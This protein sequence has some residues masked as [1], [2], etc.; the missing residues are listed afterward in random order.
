MGK[1]LPNPQIVPSI[2]CSYLLYVTPTGVITCDNVINI[3]LSYAVE[4][5]TPVN[6]RKFI[7]LPA[8]EVS[9]CLRDFTFSI[10]TNEGITVEPLRETDFTSVLPAY[11]DERIFFVLPRGTTGIKQIVTKEMTES[12]KVSLTF[13]VMP[14]PYNYN[15]ALA[16][17]ISDVNIYQGDQIASNSQKISALNGRVDAL[18]NKRL[19]VKQVPLKSYPGFFKIFGTNDQNDIL[20]W[21]FT[22]TST[23][24]MLTLT[25][26]NLASST[27]NNVIINGA[28]I[29]GHGKLVL[30]YDKGS[31]VFSLYSITEGATGTSISQQ[32]LA[33]G[34]GRTTGASKDLHLL[35]DGVELD[36]PGKG[37]GFVRYI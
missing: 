29:T 8:I 17:I 34:L 32:Y 35:I 33:S 7:I 19:Y 37:S 2:Q 27:D 4:K 12:H 25:S 14:P 23:G 30:T 26:G 21:E 24:D 5:S 20:G 28:G 18:E 3:P 11:D 22:F 16:D 6:S 10:V 15:A 31:S 1:R 9:T 13:G 36:V